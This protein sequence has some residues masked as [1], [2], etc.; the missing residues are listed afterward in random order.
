MSPSFACASFII[1][2][3]FNTSDTFRLVHISLSVD[4]IYQLPDSRWMEYIEEGSVY[5]IAV[6]NTFDTLLIT[7]TFVKQTLNSNFKKTPI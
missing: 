5:F 6:G 2:I 1:L 7:V 4:V 3:N